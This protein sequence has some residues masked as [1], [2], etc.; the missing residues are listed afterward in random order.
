MHLE[1]KVAGI[2]GQTL[3]NVERGYGPKL[4]RAALALLTFSV[5]GMSD[6][7]MEDVLSLD[8]DVLKYVFQYHTPTIRRLPSHLWLRIREA[9]SG[10]MVER[11]GGCVVWYHRQLRE[12]A[13]CRYVD[14]KVWAHRLLARYFGNLVA[15][16]EIQSKHISPQR[17]LLTPVQVWSAKA[18]VNIRRCIEASHHMLEAGMLQEAMNEMCDFERICGIVKSGAGFVLI[19]N[20]ARLL[21]MAE[22]SSDF[23][24]SKREKLDHFV[25][26]LRQCMTRIVRNP[27]HFIPDSC[28]AMQ[29]LCSSA[30]QDLMVYLTHDHQKSGVCMQECSDPSCI[31]STV[32]GGKDEFDATLMT[33]EGHLGQVWSVSWSSNS[34][35]I[36][37]ASGDKTLRLWDAS[38][39]SATMIF[40]GHTGAVT[41][42]ALS[43]DAKMIASGSQDKTIRLWNASTGSLLKVLKDPAMVVEAV[44]F[45]R[46]GN[47]VAASSQDRFIRIWNSQSGVLMKEIRTETAT[48][49]LSWSP[50]GDSIAGV[51][52]KGF[53]GMWECSTG[54]LLAQVTGEGW[55]EDWPAQ[56]VK[57]SPDGT[58]LAIGSCPVC[59]WN[60]KTKT[61]LVSMDCRAFSVAWSPDARFIATGSPSENKSTLQ[62]WNATT[63]ELLRT[64]SNDDS[65]EVSSVD[66]SPDGQRLVT[67]QWLGTLIRVWNV[68]LES[69]QVVPTKLDSLTVSWLSDSVAMVASNVSGFLYDTA[70]GQITRTRALATEHSSPVT[71]ACWSPNGQYIACVS[72]SVVYIY[73]SAAKAPILSFPARNIVWS[74]DSCKIA[75]CIADGI[76]IREVHLSDQKPIKIPAKECRMAWS[77]NCKTLAVDGVK[78]EVW[79]IFTGAKLTTISVDKD[80]YTRLC[81]CP[82]GN[83]LA[84]STRDNAVT[85]WSPT[86]PAGTQD[87]ILT[88]TGSGAYHC[89]DSMS[90]SRD[91]RRLAAAYYKLIPRENVIKLWDI[92]DGKVVMTLEAHTFNIYSLAWNPSGSMLASGSSDGEARIWWCW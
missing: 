37:S 76:E 49:S 82:Q 55:S 92:K 5:E 40:D 38:T 63:G 59:I 43:S 62:V 23:D 58:R 13:E 8:E 81:W 83:Q 1:P 9:L 73:S 89:V 42:A 48:V 67:A 54:L 15:D 21:R 78:V 61:C 30:R 24:F 2:V 56:A 72:D 80:M 4:V 70:V 52:D 29:P 75:L 3:E 22:S 41:C 88:T 11:N 45:S 85:L 27:S 79:D 35:N 87:K 47:Y 36:L 86:T 26:W 68:D 14:E 77:P 28:T 10:L 32:M 18:K 71:R 84:I 25:R 34:R 19:E 39:G 64:F 53:V 16:G 69:F 46:D 90:W 31:A 60:V 65:F 12:V 33:L 20:A 91:G 51:G 6:T 7:E 50:L 17:L 74:P 57:W 44:Q 66:W